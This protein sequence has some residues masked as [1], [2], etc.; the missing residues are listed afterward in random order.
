M[1]RS[2]RPLSVRHYAADETIFVIDHGSCNEIVLAEQL[3][4]FSQIVGD[5]DAVTVL[6]DQIGQRHR[7]A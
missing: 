4:D 5:R 2:G 1:P 7:T 3:G 6:V